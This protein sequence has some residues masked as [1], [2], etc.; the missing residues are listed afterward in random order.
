MTYTN[1]ITTTEFANLAPEVDTSQYTEPTLSG[2]ISQSSRQVADYIGYSPIAE[3]V[4]DEVRESRV[5]LE[6]DL[7]V[8]P[9]K[10]PVI[11]VSTIKISKGSPQGDLSLTLTDS[12]GAKYNIDF[13]GRAIRFPSGEL[14]L[15]GSPAFTNF[16]NLRG[17]QFYT[18]LSYRGGYEVSNLPDVIKL[19]T[20]LFTRDNLS[21]SMNSSGANKISQGGISLEFS[22]R[23]D[24]KS[25]LIVDAE[26]I[27]RPYKRIG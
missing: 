6:G 3:D 14:A 24:S 9:V 5:S 23:K 11:S 2:M 27:L 17:Q 7:V 13:T 26:R 25:D 1:L 18:K 4:V 16:Y 8:Y 21:R 20:V 10:I 19:A 12:S 22:D 15:T